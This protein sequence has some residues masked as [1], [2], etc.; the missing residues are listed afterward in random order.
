MV[1]SEKATS[2]SQSLDGTSDIGKFFLYYENVATRSQTDADEASSLLGYLEGPAFDYYFETFSEDGVLTEQVQEFVSVRKAL[3]EELGGLD[4]AQDVVPSATASS[5]ERK[6]PFI[7][8]RNVEHLFE[9]ANFNKE[10][11]LG[12]LRN[13]IMAI[14]ELAQFVIY[15]GATD[16]ATTKKAVQDFYAH[17]MCFRS[18]PSSGYSY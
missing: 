13:T 2:W 3:L 9:K 12:L 4:G 8:P 5:I 7:L 6:D 11:K 1:L 15:R 16:V 14:P 18:A 17:E 10:A